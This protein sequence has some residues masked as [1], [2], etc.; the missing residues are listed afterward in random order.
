MGKMPKMNDDTSAKYS[1]NG[2][3]TEKTFRNTDA[4]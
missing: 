3:I 1:N 4:V 2:N